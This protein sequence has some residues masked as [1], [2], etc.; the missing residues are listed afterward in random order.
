MGRRYAEGPLPLQ[1][2]LGPERSETAGLSVRVW[3]PAF[4]Q[5]AR[6]LVVATVLAGRKIRSA[7]SQPSPANAML[8][9]WTTDDRCSWVNPHGLRVVFCCPPTDCLIDGMTYSGVQI[10][11]LGTPWEF[12]PAAYHWYTLI[13]VST[14]MCAKVGYIIVKVLTPLRGILSRQYEYA[15]ATRR[16]RCTVFHETFRAGLHESHSLGSGTTSPLLW[17]CTWVRGT[18]MCEFD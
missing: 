18:T 16:G 3:I 10:V 13:V 15:L 1:R 4:H 9:Y 17:P 12:Q 2:A 8:K 5:W 14:H 11:N 7:I 6:P